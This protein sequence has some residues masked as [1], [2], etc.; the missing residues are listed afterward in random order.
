MQKC[1]LDK[2]GKLNAGETFSPPILIAPSAD[3]PL[4]AIDGNH[5]VVALLMT[6]RLKG[7]AMYVGIHSDVA[8]YSFYK[9]YVAPPVR[10]PQPIDTPKKEDHA[11]K[12][13]G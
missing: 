4:G 6:N 10:P 11:P 9:P 3:A 12:M 1:I 7:Y 13:S 8:S 2:V 5:R